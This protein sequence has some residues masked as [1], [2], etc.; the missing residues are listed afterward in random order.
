MKTPTLLALVAI[1]A[2]GYSLAQSI[3]NPD[4]FFD[5]DFKIRRNGQTSGLL[6]L[7]VTN[8]AVS[9]TQGENQVTWTHSAG[10]YAQVRTRVALLANVN[11]ELAA[12]TATSGNSLVFGREINTD[13]QLLG[14][15]VDLSDEL[16]GVAN[17]VAGAS[18]LYNWQSTA[19]ISGLTIAP[20]QLY[21]VNFSVTS[22]AGLPV[23]LLTSSSFGI[24]TA[25]ITGG[26]TFESNSAINVLNLITTG[27]TAN[28][29]DYTLYFKSAQARQAL[30]FSFAATTGVGV[31][32]LGGTAQNQNV[33]TF[34]NFSVTPIPEPA[35][36]AL[37]GVFAGILTFRRSRRG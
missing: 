3:I 22:G 33:L 27:Q 28:N 32:L 4:S 12:Y 31:S 10:G 21:K 37:C 15:L 26:T 29:K 18:V 13:F 7:K 9:G 20:D 19:Q 17:S 35:S 1:L 25:G 30:E 2:P 8:A 24:T 11:A 16:E 14:G 36:L 6:S 5:P 23:N 34:S